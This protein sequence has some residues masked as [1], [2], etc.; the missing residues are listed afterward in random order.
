MTPTTTTHATNKLYVDAKFPTITTWTSFNFDFVQTFGAGV[1]GA[2]LPI[3][4][5]TQ[6]C[7][8]L[9]IDKNKALCNI[10]IQGTAFNNTGGGAVLSFRITTGPLLYA[11]GS[12]VSISTI[13]LTGCCNSKLIRYGKINYNATATGQDASPNTIRLYTDLNITTHA[14]IPITC[15]DFANKLFTLRGSFIV[16][17]SA[18]F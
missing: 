6:Q 12:N 4:Y 10:N 2:Q 3:S 9:P 1:A 15:A 16:H 8:Y 18:T 13:D 5:T 11:L 17:S 14:E 7:F